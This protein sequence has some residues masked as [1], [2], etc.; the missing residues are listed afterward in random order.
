MLNSIVRF[1]YWIKKYFFYFLSVRS[2]ISQYDTNL[3]IEEIHFKLSKKK[4][5]NILFNRIW[6]RL[7]SKM[8]V[9]TCGKN[10]NSSSGTCSGPRKTWLKWKKKRTMQKTVTTC[11]D[12]E[13][14]IC[15]LNC[16]HKHK[17][18]NIQHKQIHKV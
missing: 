11:M 9:C 2:Y 10:V 6:I 1:F 13:C 18:S 16:E 4:I 8:W 15:S 3:V 17:K 14:L 12:S 5:F 7:G